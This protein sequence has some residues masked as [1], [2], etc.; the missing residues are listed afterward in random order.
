MDLASK[1]C[2]F[3]KKVASIFSY[4]EKHFDPDDVENIDLQTMEDLRRSGVIDM[5]ALPLM[6]GCANSFRAPFEAMDGEEVFRKVEGFICSLQLV[7]VWQ[8]VTQ[9]SQL[10]KYEAHFSLREFMQDVGQ[11]VHVKKVHQFP[12]R[13]LLPKFTA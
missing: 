2:L 12:N 4:F 5:R 13:P 10:Q 11:C 7:V 1:Q 9:P 8:L 3:I 6:L